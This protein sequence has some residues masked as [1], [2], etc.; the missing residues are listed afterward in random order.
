MSPLR[1]LGLAMVGAVVLAVLVGPIG[2]ADAPTDLL[3]TAFAAST[4]AYL[5]I[6]RMPIGIALG[7]LAIAGAALV[8]VYAIDTTQVPIGLFV[9]GAS[10]PIRRPLWAVLAAVGAATTAHVIVQVVGGYDTWPVALAT[11]AG[12]AFFA[13]IG[14]LLVTERRQRERIE[15]LLA[16]VEA[17]REA[18]RLAARQAERARVAREIHDVL[19]HTLSGLAIR[20]E[21]ARLLAARP[22]TASELRDAVDVS[23]Q[24]ARTGLEEARRAVGAL[25]GE[26]LP[27]PQLIP[28]LVA[29]HRLASG[30]NAEFDVTGMP[31]D[32]S[33]EAGLALYRTAQEALTNIRKHTTGA[34]CRVH[35][36]WTPDSVELVIHDDGG[37]LGAQRERSIGYGLTGMQE[38]AEQLG[39]TLVTGPTSTG[40]GV[41]L[42]IPLAPGPAG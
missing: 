8:A 13:L 34:V 35:L 37:S 5:T 3:L 16:A 32:V 31:V 24:L 14:R 15:D 23:H 1:A 19:A 9:L 28:A 6:S 22:G 2:A 41:L 12:V 20:L 38:R 30:A 25:R 33:A 11:L 18:E 40:F 7:C 17:G 42:R 26:E 4:G 27:G 21:S 39:A 10:A 29:E 36:A